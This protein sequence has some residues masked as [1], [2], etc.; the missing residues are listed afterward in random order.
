M[1]DSAFR[2]NR[3]DHMTPGQVWDTLV[4]SQTVAEFLGGDTVSAAV[5]SYVWNSPMCSDLTSDERTCV[6][7]ALATY[8]DR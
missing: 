4:G 5:E 2:D 6:A 7:A 8:C 3:Y 1:N